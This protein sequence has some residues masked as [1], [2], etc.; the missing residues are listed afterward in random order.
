M[1][2]VSICR[3]R[4][5]LVVVVLAMLTSGCVTTIA[6]T[7][8]PAERAEIPLPTS[9]PSVAPTSGPIASPTGQPGAVPLVIDPVVP[10]WNVVRSVKRAAVYDVPPTWTVLSEDTII[11]YEDTLGNRVVSTGAATFGEDVCGDN[12]NLGIAVV[13]HDEGTDLAAASRI[14][15]EQWADL[16]YRDAENAR[17]RLSTAAPETITTTAGRQASLVKVTARP[18]T[19]VTECGIT[20]GSAWALAATGFDGELGPTVVL[21]VVAD[22]GVPGALPEAEIRQILSSLRPAT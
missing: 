5:A 8:S 14:N 17:P 18:S 10:G 12:S 3:R 22:V 9:A 16:A 2:A 19:P 1:S 21:V 15:A 4:G 13:R 11:G 6:G 20:T 7:A